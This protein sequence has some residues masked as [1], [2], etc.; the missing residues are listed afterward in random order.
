MS[1]FF[2]PFVHGAGV[3]VAGVAAFLYLEVGL[4]TLTDRLTS[5][6]G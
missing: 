5:R 4:R 6:T 2:I 3:L 1:D